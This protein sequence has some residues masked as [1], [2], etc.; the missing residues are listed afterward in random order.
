MKT[1]NTKISETSEETYRL[2]SIFRKLHSEPKRTLDNILQNLT[3][4]AH[5]NLRKKY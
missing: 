2:P 3:K 5:L 4:N 1:G